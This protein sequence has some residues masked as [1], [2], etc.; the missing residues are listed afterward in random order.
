[1]TK[2]FDTILQWAPR[3]AGIGVAL[4]L[5]IFA[6]DAETIPGLVIHLAPS[7]LVLAAV[8]IAWKY[9]L[10]GAA[11]LVGLA[12]FY[13]TRVHWRLGWVAVIGGPLVVV[14]A[15]F[16]LSWRYNPAHAANA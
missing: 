8:A 16:V 13:A 7:A 12:L 6:L 14:A 11:A 15:L 10:A 5:A 2:S 4:F 1:M 9:P 3:I